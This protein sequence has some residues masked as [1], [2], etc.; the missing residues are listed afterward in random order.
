M[1]LNFFARKICKDRKKLRKKYYISFE[2]YPSTQ[3]EKINKKWHHMVNNT[4]K[5]LKR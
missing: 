5:S 4:K 1:F 3:L 2:Y